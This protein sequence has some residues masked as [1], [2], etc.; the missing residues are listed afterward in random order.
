M[1]TTG[2][3]NKAPAGSQARRLIDSFT[4]L[5]EDRE[6]LREQ[7]E[8][9][10]KAN[11]GLH[12]ELG[13]RNRRVESLT[14]M[15]GTQFQTIRRLQKELNE[16]RLGTPAKPKTTEE[17]KEFLSDPRNRPIIPGAEWSEGRKVWVMIVECPD[18]LRPVLRKVV[19]TDSR[20]LDPEHVKKDL[21]QFRCV[22]ENRFESV[23]SLFKTT[24]VDKPVPFSDF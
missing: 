21:E 15:H 10:L 19:P 9:L 5:V 13:E 3:F 12:R 11:E 1:N 6:A 2:Q 4:T 14:T 16:A 7:V 20:F 17:W 8:K 22:M 24:T 23:R 18:D